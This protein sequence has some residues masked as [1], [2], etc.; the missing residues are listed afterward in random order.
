MEEELAASQEIVEKNNK[1]Y[2]NNIQIQTNTFVF[3]DQSVQTKTKKRKSKDA[4]T[5]ADI[6]EPNTIFYRAHSKSF[7][8]IMKRTV[9][10]P[11]RCTTR[12]VHEFTTTEN[13]LKPSYANS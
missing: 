6:A 12:P 8:K 2:K 7:D 4:E 13:A 5:Q 10:F 9:P 11:D 3:V 1:K